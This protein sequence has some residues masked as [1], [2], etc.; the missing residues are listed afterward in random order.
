M[1]QWVQKIKQFC[2]ENFA[3][4]FGLLFVVGNVYVMVYKRDYFYPYNLLPI[5]F[6]ILYAAVFHLQQLVFFLAFATPLA[7]GLKE[8][9]LSQG[10]D[11]S[12]PTE[13]VMAGIM[14]MYLINQLSRTISDRKFLRHSIT[15]IIFLQLVWMLITTLSSCDTLVSVKY[16][17]SRLWFIFSCYIIIPHLFQKRENIIKLVMAYSTAMGIVVLYTSV[18]HLAYNFNHKAAD[19]VVSPFYNDHTAYGA[20]LAMF[21][22]VLFT[23]TLMKSVSKTTRIMAISFFLFFLFGTIVS[24]MWG[25][26]SRE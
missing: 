8:M 6:F 3:L 15:Q 12:I 17:I 16:L 7:I 5:A 20:A 11:L 10:P 21:I 1:T 14:L 23:I 9:G 2:W 26:P 13:P 24:A 25:G 4:L 19:W 22:P 18:R